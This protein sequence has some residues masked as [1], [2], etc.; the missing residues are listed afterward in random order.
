MESVSLLQ[1]L[2]DRTIGNI[3]RML[4]TIRLPKAE[5]GRISWW[6]VGTLAI[7]LAYGLVMLFSASYSTGYAKYG[8]I[9]HFIGPQFAV[10]VI[11]FIGMMLLS[12]INYRSLRYINEMF[13]IITVVLLIAALLSPEDTNG[14]R[15]WVYL[16]GMSIQ[17]GELAKFST[18]LWTAH[19][20]DLHQETRHT[21][22]D[23]LWRPLQPL[24]LTV[25]LLWLE[26][27]KSAIIITGAIFATMLVCG[28]CALKYVFAAAPVAGVALLYVLSK[29]QGYAGSRMSGVWGITPTDISGMDW[30]T[31]QSLYAVSSGGMFGVGIGNSVQK[32]QWLPYA[33]NDFIF[34][35]VCEELG[36]V[37]AL[38][39]IGLFVV[40][41]VQGIAIAMRAPDFYGSMLAIGITAQ[42]AF[43]CFFH[44]GVVTALIPNTGITLPFFSSGGTSLL[45]LLG[46]MGVLLSI[47]RAGN[48]REENQRKQAR[49]A[50]ER[51]M[52]GRLG[53]R[54]VHRRAPR[55]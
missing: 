4:A 20:T 36:F 40:L 15:R 37:G 27:H 43:Q 55:P 54:Q 16:P 50:A 38:L 8:S 30:Q 44:I 14:C 53:A 45:L 7:T 47:S 29:D 32:H 5:R 12:R 52:Q 49:A 2:F 18:I 31:K 24:L 10:A 28:G 41:I 25:L 9:Y 39:V 46:E 21:L 19:V 1:I 13:Y 26:P 33:E 23:G 48:A 51:R 17:P 6:F 34:S 42:I 22:R 11:G 35:I 3:G